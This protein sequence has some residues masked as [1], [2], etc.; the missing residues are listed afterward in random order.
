MMERGVG[1]YPYL[2]RQT[3]LFFLFTTFECAF[4]I[5]L[6]FFSRDC[7]C[8]RMS[9]PRNCHFLDGTRGEMVLNSEGALLTQ[10]VSCVCR[11]LSF[12]CSFLSLSLLSVLLLGDKEYELVIETRSQSV[13]CSHSSSGRRTL[14]YGSVFPQELISA[15]SS[16]LY[17]STWTIEEYRKGRRARAKLNITS[18]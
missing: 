5:A 12:S 13:F 6:S 11:I 2:H 9:L 8:H 15:C 7:P 10:I 16:R 14:T 4:S 18:S 3:M 17:D 1:R